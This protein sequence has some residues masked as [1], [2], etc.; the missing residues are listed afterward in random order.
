MIDEV[1]DFSDFIYLEYHKMPV[2]KILG[3]RETTHYLER[4]FDFYSTIGIGT[5]NF[6]LKG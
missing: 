5:E 6:I 4:S 1:Y 2:I 3:K